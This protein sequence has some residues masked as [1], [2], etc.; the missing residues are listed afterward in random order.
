MGV[1]HPDTLAVMSQL[2]DMRR[3]LERPSEAATVEA[4]IMEVRVVYL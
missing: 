2:A 3:E 1:D 4:A